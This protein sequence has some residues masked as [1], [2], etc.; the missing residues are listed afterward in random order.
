MFLSGQKNWLFSSRIPNSAR[1]QQWTEKLAIS[2][3]TH[4]LYLLYYR[5]GQ[6]N[7]QFLLV[8][9]LF[10]YFATVV[11]KK[12][13]NFCQY[14]SSLLTLLQKWTKK[15]AFSVSTHP[16][17]LLYYSSGQKNWQ[18]LLVL[19]LFTYSFY[20]SGQKNW[21]IFS[22]GQK[23]WLFS[24]GFPNSGRVHLLVG[25]RPTNNDIEIP[26]Q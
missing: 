19:S 17:Y 9:I 24:S 13:G 25:L 22:S 16:L 2:V 7:W 8:L 20:T 12:I 14:S 15:L 26:I 18:V 6:K 4:P 1:V 5:S 10:T 23:N 11:D 3:S 21:Q